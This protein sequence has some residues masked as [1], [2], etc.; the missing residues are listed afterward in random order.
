MKKK[1]VKKPLFWF[2]SFFNKLSEELLT[3]NSS[4]QNCL[5][6]RRNILSWE[7][8]T[9]TTKQQNATNSPNSFCRRMRLRLVWC[10]QTASTKTCWLLPM[11][12]CS[13]SQSCIFLT[14]SFAF[15]LATMQL[16][17]ELSTIQKEVWLYTGRNY[18]AWQTA[19]SLSSP[20]LL[21]FRKL[22]SF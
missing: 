13:L 3:V 6:C 10:F 12:C 5:Y 8:K 4:L 21:Q 18:S 11:G 9:H 1:K 14:V 22:S 7:L 17:D 16:C 20:N 15:R 2:C 19:N